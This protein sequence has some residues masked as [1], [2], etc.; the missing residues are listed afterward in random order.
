V[1]RGEGGVLGGV[2]LDLGAARDDAVQ[3]EAGGGSDQGCVEAATREA[4]PDHY[5]PHQLR[6]ASCFVHLV[7]LTSLGTPSRTGG[8]HDSTL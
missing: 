7:Y 6:P 4:E 1:G 5:N 3:G 2:L 8:L